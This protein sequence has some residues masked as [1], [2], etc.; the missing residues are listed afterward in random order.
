MNAIESFIKTLK[1]VDCNNDSQFYIIF[2]RGI[3][4]LKI[5]DEEITKKFDMSKPSLSRWKN[6]IT[7][8]HPSIRKHVYEFL[9]QKAEEILN[10]KQNH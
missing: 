10:D 7:A 5:N 4:L 3:K 6:N 8:P 2:G 1:K 9:Q